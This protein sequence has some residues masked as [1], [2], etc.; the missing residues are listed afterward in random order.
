[1][2]NAIHSFVSCGAGFC[3]KLLQKFSVADEQSAFCLQDA[4]GLQPVAGGWPVG[5]TPEENLMIA[6]TA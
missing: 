6:G 4:S 2:P 1:M 3:D 5:L